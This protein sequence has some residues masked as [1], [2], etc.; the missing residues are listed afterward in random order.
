MCDLGTGLARHLLVS[1]VELGPDLVDVGV[2]GT[3]LP[4]ETLQLEGPRG[5]VV[6]RLL[7]CL[8]QQPFGRC[9]GILKAYLQFSGSHFGAK[10]FSFL[11]AAG[12]ERVRI[13]VSRGQR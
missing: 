3:A 2:L 5:T 12:C 7:V 8:R 11:S 1:N 13:R 9:V 10:R 6:L 4:E